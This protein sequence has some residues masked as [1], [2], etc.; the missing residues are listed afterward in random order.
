[1]KRRIQWVLCY[2]AFKAVIW[3]PWLLWPLLPFAGEYAYAENFDDFC[4]N[5][6]SERNGH[7]AIREEAARI[8]TEF[9]FD[10]KYEGAETSPL[11]IATA[12]RARTKAAP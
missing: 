10:Q 7:D 8:A 2:L 5:R 11:A 6:N 3:T 4:S 9:H 12:I 1:M